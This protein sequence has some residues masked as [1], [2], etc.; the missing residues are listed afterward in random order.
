MI[1]QSI[2]CIGLLW[3][4]QAGA[5]SLIQSARPFA[6]SGKIYSLI[7][8]FRPPAVTPNL[9]PRLQLTFGRLQHRTNIVVSRSDKG[10]TTVV[11][12]RAHYLD[13]VYHH[14][15]D[16]S[17]YQ[18]TLAPT[19]VRWLC[20]EV[21]APIFPALPKR[22]QERLSVPSKRTPVFY[23][24]PKLH[25]NSIS[26]HPIM[27]QTDGPLTYWAQWVHAELWPY[28]LQHPSTILNTSVLKSHV[29]GL[30]I[31]DNHLFLCS[32][33]YLYTPRF[34]TPKAWRPFRGLV[35]TQHV[36]M[37]LQLESWQRLCISS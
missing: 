21:T 18:W 33:W 11:L 35:S 28:V 15:N 17:L 4:P 19:D 13:L 3:P 29:E 34:L 25:K 24:F 22:V 32:T 27:S 10:S 7:G 9:S 5:Q 31:S 8:N 20:W 30:P 12:P 6:A 16:P 1:N 37:A 36:L 2:G 14:L 26:L 23:G